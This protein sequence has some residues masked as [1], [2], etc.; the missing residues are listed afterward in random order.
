M[1]FVALLTL[2]DGLRKFWT[3]E[4]ERPRECQARLAVLQQ[5]SSSYLGTDASMIDIK[6]VYIHSRLSVTICYL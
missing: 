3:S 1:P 6:S 5:P 4:P 2:R